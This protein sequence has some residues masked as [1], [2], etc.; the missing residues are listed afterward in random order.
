[1]LPVRLFCA[2]FFAAWPN[3]DTY[4][5]KM[6]V[7]IINTVVRGQN[8]MWKSNDSNLSGSAS[9]AEAMEM[10]L[11]PL[12]YPLVPPCAPEPDGSYSCCPKTR[13]RNVPVFL[14]PYAKPDNCFAEAYGDQLPIGSQWHPGAGSFGTDH[15][16]KRLLDAF[17][18]MLYL[19]R[20]SLNL[21]FHG[22]RLT[23]E[24]RYLYPE[25]CWENVLEY[26]HAT[27]TLLAF[28]KNEAG[29]PIKDDPRF[30]FVDEFYTEV[31][32]L[33]HRHTNGTAEEKKNRIL[34]CGAFNAYRKRDAD[35]VNHHDGFS[36]DNYEWVF[37][38]T[39]ARPLPSIHETQVRFFC[40]RAGYRQ[41][42][43][44]MLHTI[45]E[46]RHKFTGLLMPLGTTRRPLAA[47][48]FG[49]FADFID[50]F[51]HHWNPC[52]M[53][54]RFYEEDR[55]DIRGQMVRIFRGRKPDPRI[56]LWVYHNEVSMRVRAGYLRDFGR[57]PSSGVLR[58]DFEL[59]RVPLFEG[60]KRWPS[61]ELCPSCWAEGSPL[62]GSSAAVGRHRHGDDENRFNVGRFLSAFNL[63]NVAIF[64]NSVYTGGVMHA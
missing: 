37:K 14:E 50:N 55:S 8:K 36:G 58:S 13:Q 7:E 46:L 2:C 40:D 33:L 18:A 34:G 56:F 11:Y 45:V 24:E 4:R 41:G 60:D 29:L 43:W 59:E 57:P 35:I 30:S 26:L 63:K 62:N 1:M 28:L 32:S 49:E 53:C 3:H 12:R 17:H 6:D 38:G 42:M 22:A 47:Y 23:C 19:I 52:P 27:I 25:K 31:Q 64:L 16:P 15:L 10:Q 44:V 48:N 21:E 61:R 20:E 9:L 54:R 39:P 5:M 51:V